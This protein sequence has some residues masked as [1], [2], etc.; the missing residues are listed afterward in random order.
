MP[1][2]S[3]CRRS[4]PCQRQLLSAIVTVSVYGLADDGTGARVQNPSPFANA[5]ASLNVK[6]AAVVDWPPAGTAPTPVTLESASAAAGATATAAREAS[7]AA[8]V[9]RLSAFLVILKSVD[10]LE[11]LG[12]VS[13]PAGPGFRDLHWLF[14]SLGRVPVLSYV[15]CLGQ[16]PERRD[17]HCPPRCYG[18]VEGGAVGA[19]VPRGAGTRRRRRCPPWLQGRRRGRRRGWRFRGAGRGFDRGRD[20]DGRRLRGWTRGWGRGWPGCGS[21]LFRRRRGVGDGVDSTTRMVGVGCAVAGPTA[22]IDAAGCG[23]EC[24]GSTCCARPGKRLEA[25]NTN[26][27][28]RSATAAMVAPRVPVVRSVPRNTWIRRS[29]SQERCSWRRR[30]SVRTAASW[31]SSNSGRRLDRRQGGKKLRQPGD[32][33]EAGGAGRTRAD[34]LGERRRVRGREALGHERVDQFLGSRTDDHVYRKP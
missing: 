27:A 10:L 30:R 13:D 9:P 11:E 16:G 2:S 32:A 12:L 24:P 8:V 20:H 14:P 28:P 23:A 25:A 21:R 4:E 26:A 18:N 6:L 17:G 3:A 33:A 1:R 7:S 29:A 31:R 34:M 22:V 19:G 15:R 5:E